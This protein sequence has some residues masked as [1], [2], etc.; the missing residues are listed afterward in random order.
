MQVGEAPRESVNEFLG[1]DDVFG[2]AAVDGPAREVGV[3]AEVLA[4]RA[5][6]L[7]NTI[8][9]VQP[10]DSDARPLG[11]AHGAGAVPL[12]HSHDLM[13]GYYGRL[14]GRQFAFDHVQ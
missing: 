13:A 4:A 9:A 1:R 6:V 5:A 2:V 10:G 14:P 7:A 3:L 12:H 8:R 11:E